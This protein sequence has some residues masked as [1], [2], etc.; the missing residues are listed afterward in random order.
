MSKIFYDH[1]VI[2][3]EIDGEL[4]NYKLDK[5]EKDELID[6]IDQ[7]FHHHILNVILNHLPKDKHPEFISRLHTDPGNDSLMEYLKDQIGPYIEE[8]IK[9]QSRVVKAEILSEI[10]KAKVAKRGK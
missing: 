10:R 8:E 2:R 3:E 6:I 1:L 5:E 9:K 4:N 7:T